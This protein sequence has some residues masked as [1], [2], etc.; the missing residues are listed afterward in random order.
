M[1][2]W[3]HGLDGYELAS[4]QGV[5]DGEDG[6]QS[7]LLLLGRQS[8]PL[9]PFQSSV[10]SCCSSRSTRPSTGSPLLWTLPTGRTVLTQHLMAH[11]TAM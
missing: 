6:A 5:G 10:F 9:F 4:A 8:G 7:I 1:V 3:H 11:Q 2:E